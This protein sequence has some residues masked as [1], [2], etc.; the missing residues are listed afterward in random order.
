MKKRWLNI[1]LLVFLVVFPRIGL[2]DSQVNSQVGIRFYE[3]TS[4]HQIVP[5]EKVLNP[6]ERNRPVT[7]GQAKSEEAGKIKMYPKTNQSNHHLYLF[8]GVALLTLIILYWCKKRKKFVRKFNK[9][10]LLPFLLGLIGI[11]PKEVRAAGSITNLPYFRYANTIETPANN[12]F[13]MHYGSFTTVEQVKGQYSGKWLVVNQENP[14]SSA[15]IKNVGF[16][17]GKPVD[18]KIIMKKKDGQAGGEIGIGNPKSFLDIDIS[19]EVFLTYEFFDQAGNA[20]PIETSF[21]YFGINRNKYIGYNHIGKV[22]KYLVANNPTDISYHTWSDD[23][24]FWT[25]FENNFSKPW[26]HPTQEFQI[27]TKPVTKI[28]TVVKNLDNTPSSLMYETDFLASPEFPA[29]EAVDKRFDKEQQKVTLNAMQTIPNVGHGNK[30]KD[31]SVAFSLDDVTAHSQYKIKDFNVVKFDGTDIS[32]LFVGNQKEDHSYQLTL[33]DPNNENLYDTVL[34][35][36]LNLEWI[37]SKQNPVD[38]T[39]LKED[40]LNIPFTV[41]TQINHKQ[42]G[43]SSAYSSVYYVGKV[44]LNYL[45]ENNQQLSDP[46][47]IS[48]IITDSFDLSQE[49][50]ELNGYYPVK[51]IVESD[52]GIFTPEEQ[53]FVHHYKKGSPIEFTLMP[54]ENPLLFSRFSKT[55]EVTIHISYEEKQNLSFM[56]KCGD[57]VLRLKDY[58][59]SENEIQDKVN[60]QLPENWLNKEVAFYMENVKG[61]KSKEESRQVLIDHGVKLRLPEQLTFGEQQIPGQDQSVQA[62]NQKEIQ[63]IDESVLEK[64]HWHVKLK[65]ERPLTNQENDQLHNDLHLQRSGVDQTINAEDQ[66]VWQGEGSASFTDHHKIQLNLH[67]FY[68]TGAYQGSLIWTLE[69]APG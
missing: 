25:Y 20:F 26:G 47:I 22:A 9:I 34:N 10:W 61:Q 64:S 11:F 24:S 30:M 54:K 39:N 1:L 48:G 7:D 55:R 21:N 45:D 33:K 53:Q 59:S 63:L 4:A 36:Q 66:L 3:P 35:Y 16:F 38:K 51:E 32:D 42:K 17:N 49:Y 5:M 27:I 44:I 43:T 56:A 14:E 19:G 62:T 67:P 46:K 69:D 52:Q 40:Y 41:T 15:L 68:K 8:I 23:H 12:T 28:E 65:E 50:P 60:V 58:P 6:N 2:A 31:L 37:G 57:E 29:A 18:V 13:M